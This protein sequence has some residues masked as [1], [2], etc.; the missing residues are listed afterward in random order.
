MNKKSEKDLTPEEYSAWVKR[1]WEWDKGAWWF[2]EE[3][4][5]TA[6]ATQI[7]YLAMCIVQVITI[8][9]LMTE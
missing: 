5:R 6:P 8:V 7:L 4:G 2:S 9:I 1:M 3:H